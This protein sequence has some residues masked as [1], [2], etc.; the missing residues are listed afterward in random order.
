[1]NRIIISCFVGLS[2]VFGSWFCLQDPTIPGTPIVVVEQTL[3]ENW[4]EQLDT[5]GSLHIDEPG[6]YI[7][8]APL[9]VNPSDRYE[10][11]GS[12]RAFV[13]YRGPAGTAWL[14]IDKARTQSPWTGRLTVKDMNVEAKGEFRSVVK[15]TY[16][17]LQWN[18]ITFENCDFS[19]GG[20]CFDFDN[21][22][23]GIVPTFRDIKTGGGGALRYRSS[24]RGSDAFHA[25]SQMEITGWH[26]NGGN[27]I[28]P[29]FDLRG[30][31]G[32]VATNIIDEQRPT[33]HPDIHGQYEFPISFRLESWYAPVKIDGY[34]LEPWGDMSKLAPGCW[35]ME[36]RIKDDNFRGDGK[37]NICE[38]NNLQLGGSN[39]VQPKFRVVGGDAAKSHG[40]VVFIKNAWYPKADVFQCY[41]KSRLVFEQPTMRSR[42]VVDLKNKFIVRSPI[43]FDTHKLPHIDGDSFG[44]NINEPY[45]EATDPIIPEIPP[46]VNPSAPPDEP[47]DGNTPG[48][49]D[50]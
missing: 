29:A 14:E 42:D 46:I 2:V 31:G 1:M 34:W 48:T 16:W 20:Y 43:V 4:Q 28:G 6:T 47:D 49:I 9:H 35:A 40:C 3:A 13:K 33:V 22:S 25:T 27:R 8:D 41:G 21:V 18:N 10:I 12:V 30:I 23:Y 36:V 17:K 19:A 37:H 24:G 45:Y 15:S 32:L 38:F 39:A 50:D 26:H 44:K 7:L 11:I 5:T